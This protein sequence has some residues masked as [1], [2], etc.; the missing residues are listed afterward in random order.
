MSL[1]SA[2]TFSIHELTEQILLQLNGPVELIRAQRV[3][4]LWRDLIQSSPS[5]RA[6]CWYQFQPPSTSNAQPEPSSLPNQES[7]S[8]NPA[9]SRIGV[10]VSN[11]SGAFDLE[12]R[13]YDK[14][15]SWTTMLATNPPCQRVMAECDDREG[16]G[17]AT[18]MYMIISP[19]EHLLMGDVM[20]VLA[21]CQN[22]QQCGLDRWAGVKH[23]SGRI[24]PWRK[25]YLGTNRLS[26]WDRMP[27]DNVSVRV[28]VSLPFG[29]GTYF[30]F[31]LRRLRCR[32]G[33][34][35]LHEMVVHQM[36]MQNLRVYRSRCGL[37]KPECGWKY[38]AN[39]LV[40]R[41][42]RQGHLT[43]CKDS[44]RLISDVVG[45]VEE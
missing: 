4:R 42:Y 45:E 9:F 11:R 6:A 3:C 15:G 19:K 20:A 12:R 8:L 23:V 27:D 36:V 18:L 24:I 14:H 7:W 5:L 43:F 37:Q 33:S 41:E 13:I 34:V 32:N 22:R 40:V 44:F 38:E 1:S 29:S 30:A 31:S 25:R 2:L 28:A 35:F 16:Y 21:E 10:S 39:L 26:P 17:D